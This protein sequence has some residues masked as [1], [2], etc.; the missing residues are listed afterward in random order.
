MN[1]YLTRAEITKLDAILRTIPWLARQLDYTVRRQDRVSGTPIPSLGASGSYEQP[2]PYN[3]VA[4]DV[5]DQLRNT[6]VGWTRHVLEQR[7]MTYDGDDTIP[8]IAQWLRRNVA[9]LALT[10]SSAE[11][12]LDIDGVVRSVWSVIDRPDERIRP[13]DER[14]LAEADRMMLSCHGIATL[15]KEMGGPF[16]SLTARRVQYLRDVGAIQPVSVAGRKLLYLVGDVRRAH[17]EYSRNQWGNSL[18]ISD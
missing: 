18:Q 12:L 2:L 9:A 10:D 3:H 14:R 8:S 11:A 5:R 1:G 13:L 15:A 16:R 17:V 7:G 4:G 6:L